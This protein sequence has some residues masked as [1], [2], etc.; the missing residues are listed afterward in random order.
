VK[1]FTMRLFK[2]TYLGLCVDDKA[3]DCGQNTL[4]VG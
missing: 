2:T 3:V 1:V 4:D